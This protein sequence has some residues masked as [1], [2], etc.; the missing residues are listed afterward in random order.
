MIVFRFYYYCIVLVFIGHFILFYFIPVQL[1]AN[2]NSKHIQSLIW[3][4]KII[5]KQCLNYLPTGVGLKMSGYN[6]NNPLSIIIAIP[7]PSTLLLL[8]TKTVI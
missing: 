7:F 2:F 8:S 5:R 4:V 3:G 1:F 6:Q